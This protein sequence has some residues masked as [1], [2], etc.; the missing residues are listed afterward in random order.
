MTGANP[1]NTAIPHRR[2]VWRFLGTTVFGALFFLLPV[3]VDGS[4]TIPFDVA[5]SA[6]TDNVPDAVALYS[7]LAIVVSAVLTGFAAIRRPTEPSNPWLDLRPFRTNPIFL[8]LRILGAVAAIMIF[9]DFGP[10]AILAEDTGGLM[11]GTLVASVAVIVPIGAVFVTMFVA[12]GGIEFIGTL[13][14]PAMR[15]LFRVPGRAALDGI[16][17]YVGSYSVGL[18]VTNRM[19]LEGRYSA[20]EAV[21]IATC[22]STVSLGFFAVVAGTL[23]L[24]GYFPLILASVTVVSL[25]LAV[26]LCRI[27]PLSRKP[28]SYVGEPRPEQPVEGSLWRAAVQRAVARA[29]QS[30]GVARESLTAL[31]DGVRL[32]L[33]ILPTILSVGLIA[34]LIA[35]HTPLFTWLGAPLEP[36]ISLLGIPDADTV[37]PASLI[38]ISE[39]FLPALIS[40]GVAIEAKFFIAV[41][42]LSQILFFSATI[43]LLLELDVPVRLRDCLTLFVLRTLLAI[44][45]VALIT[46]LAF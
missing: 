13:A 19:Y 15:P 42:S 26:V 20:R 3:K 22:F 40:T 14:K 16:A 43:P 12:F 30:D 28:D 45:L 33:V 18:Y 39:M 37:A 10:S 6:I 27:P 31:R 24:L 44:P 1:E 46:H 2:A 8:L 7:M 11:F 4:W 5:I 17:S 35:N 25:V 21:V 38:G 23:D 32:A 41:L 9:F 36:V 34:I 29:K